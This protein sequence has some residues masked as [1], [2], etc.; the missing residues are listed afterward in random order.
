MT[1]IQ[2][3]RM[4]IIELVMKV[5]DEALLEA[6]RQGAVDT[7]EQAESKPKPN[8]FDAVKPM[9]ENISLEE[10]ME[11]QNYKPID[12][13]SFRT[14]AKEI[15]LDDPIDELLADLK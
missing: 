6:I 3:K 9:R 11:E 2:L 10:L 8:P 14:L 7:I 4:S 15:E 13:K 12:F 5:S 1:S